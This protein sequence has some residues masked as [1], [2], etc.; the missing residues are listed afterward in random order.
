MR[1][2]SCWS[3]LV[4]ALV[5]PSVGQAGRDIDQDEALRLVEQEIIQ[6]LQ[7]FLDD[8]LMRYPGRFL[9]VELEWDEDRYVYELEMVTDT[10]VVLELDYDAVTGKLLEVDE[11][12]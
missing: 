2:F 3:V 4:F 7:W 5:W 8:A 12:D 11:E 6:P 9:E 10:G 1:G